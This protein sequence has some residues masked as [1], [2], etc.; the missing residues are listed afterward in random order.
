MIKQITE[1]N[2]LIADTAWKTDD[3]KGIHYILKRIMILVEDI[4]HKP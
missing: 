1:I 3:I 2:E 4:A